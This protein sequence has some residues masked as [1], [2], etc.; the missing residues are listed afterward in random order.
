MSLLR[1]VSLA[2]LALVL[3]AGCQFVSR[4]Q[5]NA[6]QTQAQALT[7]QNRK[8][9]AELESVRKQIKA[10]EEELLVTEDMLAQMEAQSGVD[11][12]RLVSYRSEREAMLK[13]RVPPVVSSRLAEL[14]RRY[15]SLNYD[16]SSGLSKFDSDVLFDEGQAE[17]KPESE[18]MLREFV[19][20]FQAPEA[21]QLKVMVV[22]HT[23]NLQVARRPVRETHPDNWRL[24]T[25]RSLAVCDFLR[26]AGLPEDRMGLA[27]FAD[28]QPLTPNANAADR[29]RNRRVEI[30]VMGPE[31]PIVGWTETIPNLY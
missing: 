22:G 31:T 15:P 25:A 26:K 13:G 16:P 3:P 2:W 19:R 20:I 30:F 11:R 27:A 17:L 28:H 14:A 10:T 6:A 21:N 18:K 5:Y 9:A 24:S 7:E 4:P 29:Q 12:R 8:L 1:T 23:D